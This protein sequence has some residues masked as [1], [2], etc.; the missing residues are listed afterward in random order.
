MGNL[1]GFVKKDKVV[2]FEYPEIAG[3]TVSLRYTGKTQ[4]QEMVKECIEERLDLRTMKKVEE[5]NEIKFKKLIATKVI[6]D[7]TGLTIGGLKNIILLDE[8]Q[9]KSAGMTNETVVEASFENKMML[10]DNSLEFD[11]WVND[12][13]HDLKRFRD[14]E[15]QK[16]VENLKS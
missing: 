8:D 5:V 2:K 13:I 10:L 15:F 12:I 6:V 16:E 3:F 9:I 11:R 7:W 14:D 1:V 4:L